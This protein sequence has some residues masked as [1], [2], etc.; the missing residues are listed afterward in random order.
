MTTHSLP[1]CTQSK[2]LSPPGGRILLC[3]FPAFRV[4]KLTLL[5][6]NLRSASKVPRRTFL[7]SHMITFRTIHTRNPGPTVS[8]SNRDITQTTLPK[9]HEGL[10]MVVSLYKPGGSSPSK[11]GVISAKKQTLQA[12]SI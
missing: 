1:G 9:A 7:A 12:L 6:N 4:A 5:P 2:R 10:H 11:C 3:P 8:D